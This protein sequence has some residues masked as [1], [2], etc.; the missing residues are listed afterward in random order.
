LSSALVEIV[1]W[2]SGKVILPRAEVDGYA[3][4]TINFSSEA[5]AFLG[6]TSGDIGRAMI[7]AGLQLANQLQEDP[8]QADEKEPVLH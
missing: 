6:E 7:G 8:M 3:L 5:K 1:E 2:A 4:V